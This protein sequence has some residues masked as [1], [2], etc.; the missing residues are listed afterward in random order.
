MRRTT[1]TLFLALFTGLPAATSLA[2]DAAKPTTSGPTT[3]DPAA[4]EFIEK[5]RSNMKNVKDL[6]CTVTQKM[7]Q[8]E[9]AESRTGT[10]AGVFQR[11]ETGPVRLT[12]FK[13]GLK[14]EDA[15]AIWA[16]DGKAC[17]KVDNTAKTFMTAESPDG[18]AFPPGDSGRVVPN[19]AFGDILSNKNAQLIGAKMLPDTE[20]DGV[21]C[22]VVEYRVELP[23]QAAPD[24]SSS[25]PKLT[26]RQVRQVGADDLIPR[27][28]ESWTTSTAP[29]NL[30]SSF[31]GTYTHVKVN[32]NPGDAAFALTAPS[33]FKTTEPEL[34]DLG[35]QS[36]ETPKMKF[37]PGE[38]APDFALKTPEGTEV[39]LASLKGRVVLLDF[40]ATW[41]GPCKMAM[42]GVQKLHEKYQG[43]PVSILGVNTWERG[44]VDGPK[45]Y[46]EG[47][48]LTYG[49]LMKGDDL[50]KKY[51]IS[52]IPTFILIGPDGK[53]L[54]IGVG[55]DENGEEELSKMID[56]AIA[57]K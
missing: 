21:H 29:E 25:P 17:Y 1:L 57:S 23:L 56:K 7:T 18:Q 36:N 52:G 41:C 44:P 13:I 6:S 28:I 35:I 11:T 39:T 5:F 45:K 46:M 37:A 16:F 34:A 26:M 48:K 20:T 32:A 27:K 19:W 55:Y 49:L 4:K 47:Q 10:F 22:R 15:D 14:N 40:W 8:G 31:V 9:T 43:K 30:A 42:P 51:G 38:S 3:V 54:H 2:Q 53:I 24:E 33:G 12:K 50:A